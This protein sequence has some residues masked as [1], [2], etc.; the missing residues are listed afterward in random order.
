MIFEA[1][2]N[3]APVAAVRLNPD[4]P[5]ELERVVN[6]ALEKNPNLRYQGAAEMRADL[7]RLKRDTES[8][9]LPAGSGTTSVRG[10]HSPNLLGGSKKYIALACAAIVLTAA[11]YLIFTHGKRVVSVGITTVPPDANVTIGAQK[12]R[13]PCDLPLP[14]GTYQLRVERD[15][16]EPVTR[17]VSVAADTKS[18]ATVT[19]DA[20]EAQALPVQTTPPNP[21]PAA[22]DQGTLIV[23]ANVGGAEVYVDGNLKGLTDVN[24]KYEGKFDVGNHE[25][26]LRKQGYQD[27]SGQI[28]IAKGGLATTTLKLKEQGQKPPPSPSPAYFVVEARPGADVL[29][30]RQ[31][32]GTVPPEGWLVQ[33]VDPGRHSIEAKLD[34]YEPWS[35][36]ATAE[37]GKRVPVSAEL[38]EIPKPKPV[39]SFFSLSAASIQR[40]QSAQLNWQ[41]DNA[42]EVTIDGGRVE[43]SGS[44]EVEPNG[45]TTYALMAKGP[46]GTDSR[47][48]TIDVVPPAAP[49]TIAP[50]TTAPNATASSEAKECIDRFK[51]AFDLKSTDELIKV[52]PSLAGNI[53]AKSGFE[54]FFKSAQKVAIQDQCV[55]PPSVSGDTTHY[56]CTEIVTY[57]SGGRTHNYKTQAVEFVCRKTSTSWVVASRTVK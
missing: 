24:E 25:I 27:S 42:D 23:R 7:Q 40:G 37:S 13:A 26:I 14:T 5:A 19:L 35:G 4:V 33:K 54:A 32:R 49:A 56:R 47:Q 34:G 31:P 18:L 16:Y 28:E 21:P 41:T 43:K 20:H 2:L 53:K 36:S 10:A 44:K 50:T 48:V 1:I 6:K 15:G 51:D 12:C 45:R 3:R 17:Q 39:I 38:V 8:G 22:I 55:E 9:M 29:I 11:G 52:W 57:M 30:D 46:G